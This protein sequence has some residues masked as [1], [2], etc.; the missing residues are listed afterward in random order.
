MNDQIRTA[1]IADGFKLSLTC[2][3]LGMTY[4][5]YFTEGTSKWLHDFH[6]PY[7]QEASDELTLDFW[8]ERSQDPHYVSYQQATFLNRV[9][10]QKIISISVTGAGPTDRERRGADQVYIHG[11]MP[12]EVENNVEFVR[13]EAMLRVV[14]KK[15]A[16]SRE[17]AEEETLHAIDLVL[18]GLL[19]LEIKEFPLTLNGM[20]QRI[21][22][23]QWDGEKWRF[24]SEKNLR[25][26]L[27]PPNK[28]LPQKC[29]IPVTAN[30]WHQ[31]HWNLVKYAETIGLR[32][33]A[34]LSVKHPI[35][36]IVDPYLF[37]ERSHEISCIPSMLDE[38]PLYTDKFKAHPNSDWIIG[39]DAWNRIWT[40]GQDHNFI[41]DTIHNTDSTIHVCIRPG[42]E[43][44]ERRELITSAFTGLNTSST[45]IR[46]RFSLGA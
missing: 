20:P 23:P 17:A 3:G 37:F 14:F 10:R 21:F 41:L 12:A 4:S 18:M 31:G 34:L 13:R 43:R 42:H 40:W 45:A 5:R 30:P 33:I 2:T 46:E 36:G 7:S 16:F 6:V 44:L 28:D 1:L 15:G 24:I 19:G 32:P 39:S 27:N 25:E 22:C 11:Y 26:L 35:K 38:A 8:E 9:F 29:F